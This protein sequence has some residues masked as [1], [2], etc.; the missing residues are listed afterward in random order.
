M[1]ETEERVPEQSV[2]LC[3]KLQD[4][5]G[6]S[7]HRAYDFDYRLREKK[8]KVGDRSSRTDLSLAVRL[9]WRYFFEGQFYV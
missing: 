5:D 1:Q 6:P 4:N 9:Y 7:A 2:R 3:I 8:E